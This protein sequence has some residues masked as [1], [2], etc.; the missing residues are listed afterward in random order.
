MI[1]VFGIV[2]WDLKP[3]FTKF[4]TQIP[5]AIQV[6][7]SSVY[8]EHEG[9]KDSKFFNLGGSGWTTANSFVPEVNRDLSVVGFHCL[10]KI[11][12]SFDAV[13]SLP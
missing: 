8:S 4:L 11:M 5:L 6:N 13:Q 7:M 9:T 3:E 2:W 10:G 12:L 1:V